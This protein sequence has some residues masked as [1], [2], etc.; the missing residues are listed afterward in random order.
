MIFFFAGDKSIDFHDHP[1]DNDVNCV[2]DE[3]N[4]CDS[5][6]KTKNISM[7]YEN[8]PPNYFMSQ[9][10]DF[11][12]MANLNKSTTTSLLSL[13]RATCSS[14]IDQIP[15]TT[16]VLWKELG[17]EIC[18]QKFYYCS[19]C[20]MELNKYQDCCQNCNSKTKANSELCIFSL[21]HEIKR[22]VESNLDVIQWYSLPEHQII[23]D[24]VNGNSHRIGLSRKYNTM[25]FLIHF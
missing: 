18:Y 5:H 12:H 17:L 21:E 11:I 1:N 25:F 13:L 15:K 7:N 8:I 2:S 19:L 3:E 6:F 23:P 14:T 16:D 22:V 10:I 4:S 20:F 9:L 24:I